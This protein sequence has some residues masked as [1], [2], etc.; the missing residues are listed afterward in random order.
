MVRDM[1]RE[2]YAAS[3]SDNITR[4]KNVMTDTRPLIRN[5]ANITNIPTRYSERT[6]KV[7]RYLTDFD[8]T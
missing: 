4:R 7:P 8:C 6:R 1:Q 5:R 2:G 3:S